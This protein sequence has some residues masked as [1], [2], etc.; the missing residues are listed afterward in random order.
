MKGC[1]IVI[2]F[3]CDKGLPLIN[4]SW[5]NVAGGGC[6][7]FHVPDF[8]KL[9]QLEARETLGTQVIKVKQLICV[10]R[11]DLGGSFVATIASE[12]IVI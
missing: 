11:C 10:V 4:G 2:Y 9:R 12:V 8:C 5:S 3:Y 1:A 7:E 6:S